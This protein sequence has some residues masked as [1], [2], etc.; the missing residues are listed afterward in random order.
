MGA[1]EFIEDLIR[2]VA[3]EA[4]CKHPDPRYA[5]RPTAAAT[6]TGLLDRHEAERAE[7]LD[8][9]LAVGKQSLARLAYRRTRAT[10]T[11]R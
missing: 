8:D 4:G 6:A 3:V 1:W 9:A 11:T 5:G 7:L 2:E 10:K